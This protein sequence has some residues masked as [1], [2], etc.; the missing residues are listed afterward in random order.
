MKGRG[1]DFISR[2]GL[3]AMAADSASPRLW[4]PA[5]ALGSRSVTGS[6]ATEVKAGSGR[7]GWSG[8][9][10]EARSRSRNSATQA[11]KKKMEMARG[12]RVERAEHER[13]QGE[14][15][16]HREERGE[17][18]QARAEPARGEAG[19]GHARSHRGHDGREAAQVVG[20]GG[21]A[22]RRR[23]RGGSR[24]AEEGRKRVDWAGAGHTGWIKLGSGAG[25]G[26]DVTWRPSRWRPRH[27]G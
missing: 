26:G 8:P 13:G 24:G 6:V 5:A 20:G 19:V 22:A 25:A 16:E 11:R 2:Q 15:R 21:A 3:A 14:E 27:G 10:P 23:Q 12:A 4:R 18:V 9:W 7:D 1:V 17:A